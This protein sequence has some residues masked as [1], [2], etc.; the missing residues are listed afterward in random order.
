MTL[1]RIVF[2]SAVLSMVFCT[3][4]AVAI[5]DGREIGFWDNH[6]VVVGKV[7][8]VVSDASGDRFSIHLVGVVATDFIIPTEL[9]VEYSP[10]PESALP[11][12][13]D[14]NM[15]ML[16]VTKNK[17]GWRLPTNGIAFFP[18][19]NA[20]QVVSGISDSIVKT[21]A[22]KIQGMRSERFHRSD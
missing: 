22:Q 14:R 3:L 18:S 8:S 16:C 5:L 4:G 1:D 9:S 10:G 20:I 2:I 15:V 19:G 7:D 17:D 11:N 12:I 13:A 6:A 21:A